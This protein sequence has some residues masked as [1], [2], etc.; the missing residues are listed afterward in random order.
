MWLDWS[1]FQYKDSNKKIKYFYK[2][3]I[4]TYESTEFFFE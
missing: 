2:L 3:D 1:G 4:S